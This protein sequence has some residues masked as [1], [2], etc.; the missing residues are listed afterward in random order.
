MLKQI[1]IGESS[2]LVKLLYMSEHKLFIFLKRKRIEAAVGTCS[3]YRVP[4]MAKVSMPC[5]VL[6]HKCRPQN[7][8]IFPFFSQVTAEL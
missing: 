3:V 4:I 8:N 7:G 5:Q 2:T 1:I 6:M